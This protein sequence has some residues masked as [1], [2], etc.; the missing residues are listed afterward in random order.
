MKFTISAIVALLMAGALSAQT[1]KDVLIVANKNVET[2][3]EVADYYAEMRGIPTDN[4]L[5]ISASE[6]E[7]ITR[8]E[9]NKDIAAPIK[10]FLDEHANVFVIVPCY[11][12]PMKVKETDRSNDK[13]V[14][15]GFIP[16]RDFCSVDGELSLLR[17]P[18]EYDIEGAVQNPTY[19][20]ADQVTAESNLMI[21]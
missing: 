15:E 9:Y 4:I 19:D 12:V 21:V 8:D 2:S 11:G 20:S 3:R 17:H 13:S 16:G 10:K 1:A 14:K 5:E 6:K 18:E 7:E